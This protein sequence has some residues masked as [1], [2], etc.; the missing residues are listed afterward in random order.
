MFIYV[1]LPCIDLLVCACCVCGV[2]VCM[3]VALYGCVCE[4]IVCMHFVIHACI[5][6]VYGRMYLMSACISVCVDGLCMWV[7]CVYLFVY[8]LYLCMYGFMYV[9][10]Y[11][12][13]N[14]LCCYVAYAIHYAVC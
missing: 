5:C 2:H 7:L 1:W 12:C 9:L 13:F 6:V 8:V 4:C 10:N 11:V 14:L 3:N